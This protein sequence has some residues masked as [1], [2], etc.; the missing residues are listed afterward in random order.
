MDIYFSNNKSHYALKRGK[1]KAINKFFRK[2][3][4]NG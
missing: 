2:D 1:I 4:S 3:R